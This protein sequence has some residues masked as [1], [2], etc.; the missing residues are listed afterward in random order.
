MQA[1]LLVLNSR[2]QFAMNIYLE[3]P[4]LVQVQMHMQYFLD[5]K[6]IL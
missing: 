5:N 2:G 1:S 4:N 3:E 6:N